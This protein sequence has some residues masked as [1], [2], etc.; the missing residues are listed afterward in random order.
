MD[1]PEP[2]ESPGRGVG[3]GVHGANVC[4]PPPG[5]A[6][7]WPRP[8]RRTARSARGTRSAARAIKPVAR[9]LRRGEAVPCTRPRLPCRASRNARTSR[10]ARDDRPDHALGARRPPRGPP[11][12]RRDLPPASIAVIGATEKAG[13]RRPDDPVEPARR[14]RSAAPSTRSTRAGPAILG[15]KA[16]PSVAA[17]GE[18][19]DLAVIVTPPR[20]RPAARADCG[21]AGVKGV[22]II[23]AGFKEVGAEG[24][25]LERQVLEAARRYGIRVVGPNCLGVM[26][27]IDR[28]NATFAAGIANPGRVGF[29]SQ[30]GAL[31]TAVLD[32]ATARERRLQLHRLAGLDARRRLGRR[33]RL[34]GRRPEHRLDRDLHGDRSATPA[35]SCP[36]RARSR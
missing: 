23:S 21:E 2:G 36:R 35:P 1:G 33:H 7:R 18:P 9:W 25:E 14:A 28:M 19:V 5:P 15:V 34:P 4:P 17:I 6:A 11:P 24:V 29:I 32:W 22:I 26:N 31:L 30:S 16:Y 12:A 8:A 10:P 20:R 3:V 27:P 13:S